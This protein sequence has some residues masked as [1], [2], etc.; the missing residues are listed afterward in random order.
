LIYLNRTLMQGLANV[1]RHL[2]CSKDVFLFAA[3]CL[4]FLRQYVL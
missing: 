1:K 3:F 4:K 2:N